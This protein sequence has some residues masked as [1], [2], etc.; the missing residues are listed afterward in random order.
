MFQISH[1]LFSKV[2]DGF[3][4]VL[5]RKAPSPF[6]LIDEKYQWVVQAMELGSLKGRL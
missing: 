5:F 3:L 1:L 2:F 6:F 4:Y